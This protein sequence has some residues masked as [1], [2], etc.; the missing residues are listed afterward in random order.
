MLEQVG[1]DQ[2]QG[3]QTRLHRDGVRKGVLGHRVVPPAECV[4]SDAV[5]HRAR[6]SICNPFID[7]QNGNQPRRP[8]AV[9]A[10]FFFIHDHH[11]VCYTGAF[12]DK[13]Y[14]CIRP[15]YR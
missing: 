11:I 15:C 2:A 6:V 10:A 14:A 3:E 12:R 13:I 5:E 8:A 1:P 9:L 4:Q 7:G